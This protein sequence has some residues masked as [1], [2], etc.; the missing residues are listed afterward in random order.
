MTLKSCKYKVMYFRNK[1]SKSEYLIDDLR[2]E[3]RINLG[4]RI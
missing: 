2:N 4:I 3:Q 1:D